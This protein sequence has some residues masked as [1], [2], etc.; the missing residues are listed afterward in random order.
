MRNKALKYFIVSLLLIGLLALYN[1]EFTAPEHAPGEFTLS[2]RAKTHILYGDGSGGGH[3]YGVGK[4]CKSEFPQEWDDADI[5]ETVERIAANDNLDWRQEGNGYF[6]SEAMDDDLKIR[7][8]MNGEQ[9]RVITAYP[10]NVPRNPCPKA[11]NDNYN[12]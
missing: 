9:N 4:P 6:V 12:R 7:V 11:A 10:I 3:K 8:V 1:G 2:N 5:I